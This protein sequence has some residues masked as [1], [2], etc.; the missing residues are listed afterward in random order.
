MYPQQ[1]YQPAIQSRQMGPS[2]NMTDSDLSSHL[3]PVAGSGGLHI[4]FFYAKVRIANSDPS[5]NG[6]YE[7][8][9]CIYKTPKGDRLTIAVRYI[10][11]EQAMQEFPREF[12]MFKQY[13]SV[14]TNGTPL[15]ELPGI[16]QSQ[17]A[18]LLLHNLRSI[19]D[20]T[21]CSQDVINGMGIDVRQAYQIAKRWRQTRDEAAPIIAQAEHDAIIEQKTEA[22]AARLAAAERANMELQAQV[23]A[24]MMM[25]GNTAQ[26]PQV[27]AGGAV[28]VDRDDGLTDGRDIASTMFEGGIVEGSSDLDD[29]PVGTRDDP[30]GLTSRKGK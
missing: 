5:H 21:E 9:L 2:R 25:S 8:R 20:V 28:M 14:P 16:S 29:E 13:E 11:E 24:L 30:L 23:K 26:V 10:T 6:K 4:Q 19:E 17:I 7:N 22:M 27:G 15:Q 3:G 1:N 12:S 18:L